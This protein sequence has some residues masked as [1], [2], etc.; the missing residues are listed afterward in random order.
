[1]SEEGER[2]EGSNW[3]NYVSF[4]FGLATSRMPTRS[5][6]IHSDIQ[7]RRRKAVYSVKHIWMEEKG[8]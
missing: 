7:N 6:V 4:A 3:P 8:I 5:I 1:M 2:V